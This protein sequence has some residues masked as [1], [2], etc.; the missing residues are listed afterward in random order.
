MRMIIITLRAVLIAY[1]LEFLE[2]TAMMIGLGFSLGWV[3]GD[4]IK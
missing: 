3:L 1:G 4:I 2:E